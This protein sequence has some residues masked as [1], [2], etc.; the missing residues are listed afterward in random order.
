VTPPHV[1]KLCPYWAQNVSVAGARL[2]GLANP[3]VVRPLRSQSAKGDASV[4]LG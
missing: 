1:L 4:N 3:F 2:T